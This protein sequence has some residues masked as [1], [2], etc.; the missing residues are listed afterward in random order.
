MNVFLRYICKLICTDMKE[1]YSKDDKMF[2]LLSSS[3]RLLQVVSRFPVSLGVGEKTI[4]QVCKESNIDVKTFLAVVNFTCSMGKFQYTEGDINLKTLCSYLQNT[5]I[6][7]INFYLPHIRRHLIDALGSS[8]DNDIT[9]LIIKFFDEYCQELKN[10]MDYEDKEVFSK[11]DALLSGKKIKKVSLDMATM[12]K[13]PIEQKLSEL[14]NIIIK[15]YNSQVDN[16]M[17]VNI[18]QHLFM[19]EYD[20][21]MHDQI[22]NFLLLPEIKRLENINEHNPLSYS[23]DKTVNEE[24]ELT[25]REKEIIKCVVKG[26]TNKEIADKLFISINTVTTHRRNIAKKL[27]IHS[28]SGLT[29]YAIVNKLVDIKE[30]K[31]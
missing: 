16:K 20:L 6:Y 18:L 23:E 30:I 28:P 4:E 8:T 14:K 25:E 15:Y 7:M 19:C 13:S 9:F 26:C 31:L 22:E 21:Y 12:H 11:A 29:I 24:E 5:H 1:K 2:E 3:E 10:H 17:I 27:D